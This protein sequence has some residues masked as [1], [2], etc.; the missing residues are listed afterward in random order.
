M[1]KNRFFKRI[2][3][4]QMCLTRF[5]IITSRSP[6]A[7]RSQHSPVKAHTAK[8]LFPPILNSDS[9]KS[10]SSLL[11]GL[12]LPCGYFSQSLLTIETVLGWDTGSAGY[13]KCHR[14]CSWPAWQSPLVGTTGA[15]WKLL[16]QEIKQQVLKPQAF[17][18]TQELSLVHSGKH[19]SLLKAC[20]P[21]N[22]TQSCC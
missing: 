16:R 12:Y 5:P 8:Y 17:F 7:P 20:H 4:K 10:Q 22:T 18:A 11:F 2:H 13:S 3:V 21:R 1:G 6:Q 15:I 19:P 14:Q 9:G